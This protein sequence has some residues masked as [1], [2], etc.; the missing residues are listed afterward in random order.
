M[1]SKAAKQA[2][3]ITESGADL[4]SP[5]GS[6]TLLRALT[7]SPARLVGVL[8]QVGFQLFPNAIINVQV[9]NIALTS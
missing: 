9:S 2:T 4:A 3:E 6:W 7:R 1:K 5:S 8:F